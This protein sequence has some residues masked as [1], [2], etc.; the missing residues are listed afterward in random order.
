MESP[1]YLTGQS[2]AFDV[3][4]LEKQAL[5]NAPAPAPISYG[6]AII[7]LAT[8]AMGAMAADQGEGLQGALGGLAAGTAA[9]YAGEK[10]FGAAKNLGGKAVDAVRNRVGPKPPQTRHVD[11]L[12]HADI[13]EMPWQLQHAIDMR[14][15]DKAF[16]ARAKQQAPL[17][18]EL[19]RHLAAQKAQPQASNAP[20]QPQQAPPAAAKPAAVKP[21]QRQG[22]YGLEGAVSGMG[23]PGQPQAQ[24]AA[25]VAA[26]PGA[27]PVASVGHGE[28]MGMGGM[29]G[30]VS[31]GS[32]FDKES[33][34][35]RFKLAFDFSLGLNVPGTPLSV[36]LKDQKD[37]LEG[38]TKWVPRE[39][40]E[41]GYKYIEEGAAPEDIVEEASRR[42]GV[43]HPLLG[44]ALAALAAKKLAP[45]SGMAGPALA[46]VLG[47]GGGSLYNKLTE[48]SRIE[49]ALQGYE[50][51][52]RTFPI[53]RHGVQTA[54]ESTP[55]VMAGGRDE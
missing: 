5:A 43:S 16:E 21:W 25:Y 19:A 55:M 37:R 24:Q 6:R 9:Q 4:G 7:P 39:D 12:G 32:P 20:A 34:L 33:S 14:N 50:G 30:G 42:G 38:M 51:A 35:R 10:A 36:N 49:D 40:I 27:K 8:A 22:S 41:R 53:R 52:K 47:A 13:R 3:Y 45:G 29:G 2:D 44:A 18:A 1:A 11:T 15:V 48:G 23:L 28:G 54:N 46:G 17:D 26:P 31:F